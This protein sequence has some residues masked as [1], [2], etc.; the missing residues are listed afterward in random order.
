MTIGNQLY[1]LSLVMKNINAT[2]AFYGSLRRG[3]LNYKVYESA[4]EYLFSARIRG[5]RLFSLSDY[6]CAVAA[7]DGAITVEIFRV[8]DPMV[9]KRIHELE[10]Q[11]GYHLQHIE[12]AQTPVGIY[13][14]E[15]AENYPEVISGDW[16]DFFRR[17]QRL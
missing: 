9:E 5:Y 16:V 7:S 11:A 2:Y 13:L 4:L 6:P 8:M 10:I 15:S 12:V 1:P 14:F 3:M 17:Q